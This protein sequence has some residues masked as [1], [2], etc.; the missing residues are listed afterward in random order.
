ML[1]YC[2]K[3]NEEPTLHYI[4]GVKETLKYLD[5]NFQNY[6]DLQGRNILFDRLYPVSCWRV[7][8]F[9]TVLLV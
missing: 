1:R 5:Q 7:G 2:G 8:S 3:P 6:I 4:K 9:F